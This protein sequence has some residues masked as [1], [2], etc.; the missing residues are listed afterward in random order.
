MLSRCVGREVEKA[1]RKRVSLR[2]R[3]RA[4]PRI[5]SSFST[6]LIIQLSFILCPIK[7]RRRL[8][9][10]DYLFFSFFLFSSQRR[11]SGHRQGVWCIVLQFSG[12][13]TRAAI[14]VAWESLVITLPRSRAVFNRKRLEKNATCKPNAVGE[15][16]AKFT[17]ST[18]WLNIMSKL[19]TIGRSL[20][21]TGLTSLLKLANRSCIRRCSESR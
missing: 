18:S 16:Q 10:R 6:L 2:L 11:G 17:N 1:R 8:I 20:C 4:D 15:K 9:C 19:T 21:M 12:H 5:G 14:A 13:V 3:Q 7:R